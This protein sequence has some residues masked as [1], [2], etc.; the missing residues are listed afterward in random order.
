MG[1]DIKTV[2]A[3]GLEGILREK[4]PDGLYMALDDPKRLIWRAA[5]VRGG[6]AARTSGAFPD[7]LA[8]L[9]QRARV[10]T[11]GRRPK[12]RVVG[13]RNPW[14]IRVVMPGKAAAEAEPGE[15]GGPG[16]EEVEPFE[17]TSEIFHGGWGTNTIIRR[18]E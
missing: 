1:I 4:K 16:P 17:R 11:R 9:F 10:T 8:W 15:G 2:D 5:E 18:T 12:A 7:V 6:K 14:A 13:A 3:A